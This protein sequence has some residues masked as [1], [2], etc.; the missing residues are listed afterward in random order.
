MFADYFLAQSKGLQHALRERLEKR[1][2]QLPGKQKD[3]RI[4]KE[5]YDFFKDHL[6]PGFSFAVGKVRNRK[7]LL[8]KSCDLLIYK[9]WCKKFFDLTGG[10]VL[11]DQLHSFVTIETDLTTAQLLN[12][13]ALTEAVKTM[14]AADRG[15]DENAIVPVYS[16]LVAY[17]SAIPLLSHRVALD[18]VAKEKDT[19]VTRETDMV[20]ILDQG[21]ILKDWENGGVYRGIE[22][23]EDTLMWFYILLLE[24]LD[25]D[26]SLGFD[27]R[28]YV[29]EP[30]EYREY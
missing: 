21:I 13:T 22:T 11:A 26:G 23:G 12:H 3:V 7:H 4:Y 9:K 6:P 24:Y 18:D 1:G 14:Y 25:R 10:Y 28:S 27:P 16:V 20:C 30:R 5:L 19:P 2:V 29:K 17:R 8:N 15:L